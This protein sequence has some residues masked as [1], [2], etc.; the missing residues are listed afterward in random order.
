MDKMTL[1]TDREIEI[2]REGGR[3]LAIIRDEAVGAVRAGM[4]TLQ[5][6]K[7]V[8]DLI[9]KAGGEA[10]FKMVRGYHHATCIN[11]NDTVV[12][13][14]PRSY[15]IKASDKV[16]IDLGLYYKGYHTDTSTT[17]VVANPKS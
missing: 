3:K 16:G 15:K 17:V 14:M 2:M 8:D 13:G 11:I 6:D 7:L 12:H 5:L 1:K 4:T 10:S 9:V